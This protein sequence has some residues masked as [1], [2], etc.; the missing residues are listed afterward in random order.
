MDLINTLF[1]ISCS[2]QRL[3]KRQTIG[4][5]FVLSRSS[6]GWARLKFKLIFVVQ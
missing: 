2:F 3:L 4:F 5:G 1:N 6:E